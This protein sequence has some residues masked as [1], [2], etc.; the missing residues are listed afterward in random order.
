MSFRTERDDFVECRKI[1]P[2]TGG[3]QSVV[4]WGQQSLI[5]RTKKAFLR[6]SPI[7]EL[8]N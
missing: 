2:L 4:I 3:R 8:L 1:A 5:T 7:E 6:G